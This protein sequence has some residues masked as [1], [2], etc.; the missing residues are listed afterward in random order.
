VSD[1]P[2]NEGLIRAL[3]DAERATA[4]LAVMVD[5]TELAAVGRDAYTFRIRTIRQALEW[6]ICDLSVPQ[7]EMTREKA[8]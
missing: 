3:R 1:V 4:G 5:A 8:A 7:L 6:A 2:S